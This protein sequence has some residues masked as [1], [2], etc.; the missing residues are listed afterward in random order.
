MG[1]ISIKGRSRLLKGGRV[2]FR[3]GGGSAPFLRG[4]SGSSNIKAPRGSEGWKQMQQ[5][6][7]KIGRAVRKR[8]TTPLTKP[9]KT[10]RKTDPTRIGRLTVGTKSDLYKPQRT[11]SSWEKKPQ[12]EKD[13]IK[14][15]V[16]QLDKNIKTIK[17][18]VAG[19]GATIAGAVVYGKVKEKVKK[20]KKDKKDKEKD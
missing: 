5:A 13:A 7:A 18:V 12:W 8:D 4:R 11:K 20:S 19:T 16:K 3:T 6:E 14:A 2:G 15:D 1:D 10:E 9:P 17:K